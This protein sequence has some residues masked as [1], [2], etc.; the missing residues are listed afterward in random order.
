MQ[1]RPSR[2]CVEQLAQ[3]ARELEDRGIVVIAVQAVE[4]EAAALTA[5]RG[6]S[7]IPFTV[8]A[9]GEDIPEHKYTWS[10]RSLPW[11]ILTDRKH[12]V[13]A[14]GFALDE[15]DAKLEAHTGGD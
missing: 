7:R 10:V 14:E 8:V 13:V 3:R 6:E 2:H 15:L 5:W 4:V 11:L 12:T 1:Q 9:I